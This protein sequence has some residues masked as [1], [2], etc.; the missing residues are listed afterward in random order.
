MSLSAWDEAREAEAAK[1]HFS[2]GCWLHYHL[3]FTLALSKDEL[4]RRV[5]CMYR[6]FTAGIKNPKYL[7][8]TVFEFGERQFDSIMEQ[9]DAWQVLELIRLRYREKP[10]PGIREAFENYGWELEAGVETPPL[11][12]MG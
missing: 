12:L 3:E 6:I 10:T 7:F 8:Y 2:L 9:G 5:D 4:D 11:E 1:E